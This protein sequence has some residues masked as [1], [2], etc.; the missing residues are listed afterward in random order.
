MV[1]ETIAVHGS[2]HFTGNSLDNCSEFSHLTRV[3]HV[4]EACVNHHTSLVQSGEELL[5]GELKAAME[6]ASEK[7]QAAK[8]K[9]DEAKAAEREELR[10]LGKQ[11]SEEV[12]QS[13]TKELR[14]RSE[15]SK[16]RSKG[17]SG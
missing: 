4:V 16:P 15:S 11:I 3:R 1:D 7:K 5:M 10:T 13:R 8:E 14:R 6:K 17:S 2:S 12:E 9:K